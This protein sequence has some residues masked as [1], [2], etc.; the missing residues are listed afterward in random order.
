MYALN[1]ADLTTVH[2]SNDGFMTML[3]LEPVLNEHNTVPVNDAIDG[4]AIVLNCDD[5]RAEAIIEILNDKQLKIRAYKFN[6][7][8]TNGRFTLVK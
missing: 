5:T 1:I 8:N 6:D 2:Q 4:S 7:G 3:M